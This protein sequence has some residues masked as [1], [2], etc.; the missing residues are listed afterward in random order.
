[1]ADNTISIEQIISDLGDGITIL[2]GG[3]GAGSFNYADYPRC[4]IAAV[5]VKPIEGI[6]DPPHVERILGDL[7]ELP[8]GNNH[9]DLVVLNY[10]L[11]H[12]LN[13]GLVVSEIARVLKPDGV[14]YLSVPNSDSWDDI[15]FRFAHKVTHPSTWSATSPDAHNQKFTLESLRRLLGNY[16]FSI[17]ERLTYPGGYNW[18]PR[19]LRNAFL[20]IC[21]T[22]GADP[23]R[24]GGIIVK[25]VRAEVEEKIYK[26]PYVCFECGLPAGKV[27]L[28]GVYWKCRKCGSM[29]IYFPPG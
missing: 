18:M 19:A 25:A 3:A 22:L 17:A 15:L 6:V 27:S 12:T 1:M 28:D 5:D 8:F 23:T 11:E 4:R 14:F 16:G 21:R 7:E 26:L 24:D 20:R 13:P 10:V 9:F 29:N 2:D